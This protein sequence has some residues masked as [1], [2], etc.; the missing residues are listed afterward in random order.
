MDLLLKISGTAGLPKQKVFKTQPLII[1]TPG[2][3]EMAIPFLSLISNLCGSQSKHSTGRTQC[4]LAGIN[5]EIFVRQW[6]MPETN[7]RL[8]NLQEFFRLGFFPSSN[9]SL[10]NESLTAC[11]Y[12][13]MDMFV[14]FRKGKL[15]AHFKWSEFKQRLKKAKV[16]TDS[17]SIGN[18]STLIAPVLFL[19]V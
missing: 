14:V 9:D 3:F 11:I 12:E 1:K 19:F 15:I 16:K 7:I 8:D 2:C 18:P 13:K 6:G 4:M 5:Q 10:G 17:K